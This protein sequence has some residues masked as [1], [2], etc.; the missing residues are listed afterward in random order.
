MNPFSYRRCLLPSENE[1]AF[2][3]EF[4]RRSG[5]LVAADWLPLKRFAVTSN[6]DLD[7]TFTSY[8]F[9]SLL[10]L[11]LEGVFFFFDSKGKEASHKVDRLIRTTDY[12]NATNF[13][14]VFR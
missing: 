3:S 6:E 2:P 5:H 11:R 8:L 14:I 1:F 10:L 4:G 13:E 9:S 12:T 7:F